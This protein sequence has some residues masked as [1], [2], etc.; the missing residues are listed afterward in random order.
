[1]YHD[2][3]DDT[4]F[5][6]AI[7]C[8]LIFLPLFIAAAACVNCAYEI[9]ESIHELVAMIRN[10]TRTAKLSARGNRSHPGEE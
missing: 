1:M 3:R 9:G 5:F 7:A 6:N 2:E 8:A 10:R 4:A